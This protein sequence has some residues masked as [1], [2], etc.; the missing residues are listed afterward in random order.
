MRRHYKGGV[1]AFEP[2]GPLA[3]MRLGVVIFQVRR[4]LP[5]THSRSLAGLESDISCVL[6]LS[7][8]SQYCSSLARFTEITER[9]GRENMQA[10][11]PRT[12]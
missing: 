8:F 5:N 11:G 3:K 2:E 1:P 9:H 12:S 6:I 10:L 4:L 7:Q